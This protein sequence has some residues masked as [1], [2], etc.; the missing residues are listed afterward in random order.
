MILNVLPTT[1]FLPQP[2]QFSTPGLYNHQ[3][4]ATLFVKISNGTTRD[5]ITSLGKEQV[6]LFLEYPSFPVLPPDNPSS[7][8]TTR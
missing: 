6:L 3:P 7:Q 4:E 2:D 5:G 8:R 1:T